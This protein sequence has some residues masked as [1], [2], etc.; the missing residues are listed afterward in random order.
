M[1]VVYAAYHLRLQVLRALKI[2]TADSGK[3]PVFR[4]RFERESQLAASLEHP[5]IVPIYE[6]GE[7]D[8]AL[9]ISMRLVDGP[10]LSQVLEDGPLSL[11]RAA[12]L[13]SNLADAL[14][15]AHD[16]GLVHRDVKPANVLLEGTPDSERV[17]LGDFGISRLMTGSR[18]LT[19]TGEMIGT[20]NYVAPEQI[21]GEDVDQRSDIYSLA[22]VTYEA[23]TG[24]APFERDTQLATMFAHAN[25]P[26]PHPSALR[27]GLSGDVDRV[28]AR[29]LAIDQ[30]ERYA[31]ASDFAADLARAIAGEPVKAKR[32]SSSR[33]RV[34]TV[35]AALAA[36]VAIAAL[37]LAGVFGGSG[38]SGPSSGQTTTVSAPAARVE[39]TVRVAPHPV[40]VAVGPFNV[41]TA[42]PATKTI[43][44][45]VPAASDR[46]QP[47]LAVDGTPVS[48]VAG[49]AS[50][51]V[52]DRSG[53]ALIRL[54]PGLG[55][56]PVRIP[57]GSRPSDVA[58]SSGA[59]WVT[60]EGDD[61]VSRIDPDSNQVVATAPAGSAPSA[62]AVGEGAVWIADA[63][64]GRITPLDPSS[65]KP[66]GV[67]LQ[68]GGSPTG[69]AAGEG[70]VWV[71]DSAQ[72]R[73][74]HISPG[75]RQ[76]SDPIIAG[77]QPISVTTGFGYA[78][79]GFADG[80]VRRLDPTRLILAGNPIHVAGK[81][82]GIAAGD[83]FVW[84][85][86]RDDSTVTRIRPH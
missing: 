47:P 13:T 59:L 77:P 36:V 56:P 70:G 84:T 73:V 38:S 76:I 6:A 43:S 2:L 83:S 16:H 21:A 30:K 34:A 61:T 67:P 44:P 35:G 82:T 86:N 65:A 19:E 80:E 39:A 58:A 24:I 31:R 27:Q 40:A 18:A 50:I 4:A 10:N 22:C 68:V 63:G 75:S 62:V 15:A 28:F 25:D 42:S 49:F 20:V 32:G 23:L 45:I 69:I 55:T 29:A 72:G 5:N 46:A 52:V 85:A 14:D 26:R 78:W 79:V 37:A 12:D 53:N 9:Y 60:N 7:A 64:D 1:A 66:S 11:Q 33:G 81:P 74:F 3:D 51:W 57:V 54:D 41:W 8:G 48:I 17:F 71:V